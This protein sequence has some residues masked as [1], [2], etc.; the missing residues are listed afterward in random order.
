M[1]NKLKLLPAIALF[2]VSSCSFANKS[3]VTVPI[4]SNPPGADVVIDGKNFGQTPAFVELAPNKNY[5]ATISKRGYGSANIDMETW[6][7]IREGE[8]GDGKRCLADSVAVLPIMMIL[9]F[10]PEKCGSFKQSDYFVDISGGR[11]AGAQEVNALENQ[12]QINNQ[13]NYYQNYQQSGSQY[14]G[15]INNQSNY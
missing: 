3:T 6:Y 9:L 2:I 8:S 10:A 11:S 15:Q 12:S 13:N 5:K 14:R 4:N 1:Q 7:S